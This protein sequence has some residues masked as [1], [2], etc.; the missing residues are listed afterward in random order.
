MWSQL[1]NVPQ[2]NDGAEC[3]VTVS[4]GVTIRFVEPTDGRPEGLS[5]IDLVVKDPQNV[6]E[7][8]ALHGCE[9]GY[10]NFV[11]SGLKFNVKAD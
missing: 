6:L 3:S 4:A 2:R 8:A 1:L 11:I 9:T 5:A 10:D 7:V